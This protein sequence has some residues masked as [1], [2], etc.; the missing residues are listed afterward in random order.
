MKVVFYGK[1]RFP[2]ADFISKLSVKDQAKILACLKNIEDIGLNSPRVSC[3]QILGK[4][5]EIRISSTDSRYRVF[6]VV[7][8]ERVIVLLHAYKKQT[9]KAPRK[10]LKIA[11]QRLL[12]VLKDESVYT[13][14]IH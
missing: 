12:E 4:L 2:V 13:R 14:T 9:Q 1:K 5:W 11:G 6:Y 7:V 10:E 8:N 3:R